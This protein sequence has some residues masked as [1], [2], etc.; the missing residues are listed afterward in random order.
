MS[1]CDKQAMRLG[2]ADSGL[3]GAYGEYPVVKLSKEHVWLTPYN[4]YRDDI[5]ISSNVKWEIK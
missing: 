2:A 1:E 5:D 3:D 4:D